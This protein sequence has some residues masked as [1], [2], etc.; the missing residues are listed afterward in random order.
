LF[1]QRKLTPAGWERV[2]VDEKRRI[3]RLFHDWKK[4]HSETRYGGAVFDYDDTLCDA[5][6]RFENRLPVEVGERIIALLR[7]GLRVG[8]ATGR[9]KSVWEALRFTLPDDLWPGIVLGLYN[10]GLVFGLEETIPVP[11]QDAMLREA[12]EAL[13][14]SLLRSAGYKI[15]ERPVQITVEQGY[16]GAGLQEIWRRVEQV[17]WE[18]GLA[19]TG[20]RLVS[21]GHSVDLIAP[22]SGK[23]K[24]VDAV[25]AGLQHP[26][27]DVLRIGDQGDVG[28]NDHDLLAHP[29]GLSVDRISPSLSGCWN[30]AP[31]GVSGV[32]ALLRYLDALRPAIGGGFT[33]NL[34]TLR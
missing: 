3:H 24:V 1:L 13:R 23:I 2:D 28:G 30:L 18:A 32:P 11:A 5:S 6:H 33:F 26:A 29:H 10:G 34:E 25:T 7:A 4:N 14:K 27:V 21:S 19:G 15:D 22:S 31:P 17:L 16:S 20:L 9:G 12:E 8:V